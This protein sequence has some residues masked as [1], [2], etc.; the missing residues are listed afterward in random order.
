MLLVLVQLARPPNH[1]DG[2]NLSFTAVCL[3][4]LWKLLEGLCIEF[5]HSWGKRL[6]FIL[7]RLC[8]NALQVQLLMARG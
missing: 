3:P 6:L 5:D 4:C 7:P 1:H 8:R 2:D